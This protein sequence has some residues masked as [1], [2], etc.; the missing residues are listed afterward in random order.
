MKNPVTQLDID[1]RSAT[2][3]LHHHATCL[4]PESKTKLPTGRLVWST[5]PVISWR[6]IYTLIIIIVKIECE[7]YAIN[8]SQV[9]LS[10]L[11]RTLLTSVHGPWSHV[12]LHGSF[13]VCSLLLY[14]ARQTWAM[15]S[16]YT[17][18]TVLDVHS[19]LPGGIDCLHHKLFSQ[20]YFSKCGKNCQSET[21]RRHK[22]D[23]CT[24]QYE[25]WK[26]M[27]SR[28]LAMR[29]VSYISSMLILKLYRITLRQ[30]HHKKNSKYCWSWLQYFKLKTGCVSQGAPLQ[31]TQ[32]ITLSSGIVFWKSDLW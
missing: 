1:W 3:L 2:T 22:I 12:L 6:T 11:H 15:L 13:N 17:I 27:S 32:G 24:L 4:K 29:G 26:L 21:T 14:S 8:V 7:T 10:Q 31:L 28:S 16:K 9:K 19:I 30:T 20:M 5:Q 23:I 18:V 25:M